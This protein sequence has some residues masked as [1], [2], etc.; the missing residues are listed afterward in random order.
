MLSVSD[1]RGIIELAQALH[2]QGIELIATGNTSALLKEHALPVT[3]VS[4]YTGVP[5]LLDGRVKTLHPA[6]HAGLLARRKKDE[7][8]LK[9]HA[10]EPIDL[11]VINLYPFEQTISQI[12]CNFSDAIE[13]I[14]IGGPAMIRSAAKKPCPYLC[15]CKTRRLC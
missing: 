15:R 5:E 10:I 3:E 1:K 14:D 7:P 11:L 4:E 2:Q 9:Q 12:D 13:N 8:T 6:I